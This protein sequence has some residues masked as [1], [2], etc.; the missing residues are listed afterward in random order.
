MTDQL[1]VTRTV[2]VDPAALFAVLAD[3]RR[4]IE[5]DD[6]GFV[7]GVAEGGV[8]RAVGDVFVMDMHNERLGDY[9]MRNTVVAYE[10]DRV[11]GWAPELYPLDGYTAVNGDM[12]ATGHSYTWSLAPA[13]GGGTEVTQTYD[14]SGV[15]DEKFRAR[16]PRFDADAL[17][18]S[19]ERLGVAV[20]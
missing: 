19:I 1:V 10:P 13:P 16:F 8:L 17:A 9:R 20:E 5:F 15:H 11:I 2:D 14:W 3:P 12:K 6:S 7:R 18:A 4:H